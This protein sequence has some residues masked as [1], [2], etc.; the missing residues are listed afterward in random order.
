[1]RRLVLIPCLLVLHTPAGTELHIESKHVNV[2]QPLAKSAEQHVAPGT[3][4]IVHTG[5]A[6][7]GVT[8]TTEEIDTMLENCGED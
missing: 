7:F 6:K 3:K 8:E 2:F 4:T 1:M 5:G